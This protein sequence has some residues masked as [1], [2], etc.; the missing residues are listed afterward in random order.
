MHPSIAPIAQLFGVSTALYEKALAG[1]DRET[2]LKRPGAESNPLLW[3][4][5]HLASSRY[6]LA[7]ALGRQRDVPWGKL[8]FRG[9]SL[10]DLST[11]PE[12]G[13]IQ[14]AWR[15]ISALVAA[16]LEELTEAELSAPAARSFAI[17]DRSTRGAITFLAYH[18]GYHIG[19]MAFLRKWLGFPGLVDG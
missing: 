17:P 3:I 7:T 4:A 9:A 8:F 10:D 11:L 5:G 19:Q 12:I 1:L 16:R 15:D 18:E 2:L 14:E 13:S 6:G